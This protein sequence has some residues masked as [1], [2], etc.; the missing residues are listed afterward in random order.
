MQKRAGQYGKCIGR[1]SREVLRQLEGAKVGDS[2]KI[3]LK[4]QEQTSD[5]YSRFYQRG[6]TVAK[7]L[8]MKVSIRREAVDQGRCY[9]RFA[10]IDQWQ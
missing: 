6:R 9:A 5:G 1:R 3:E 7:K 10:V 8:K 2:I 4:P